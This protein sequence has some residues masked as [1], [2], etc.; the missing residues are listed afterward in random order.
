MALQG[1]SIQELQ[2]EVAAMNA[3]WQ[4]GETA[5]TEMSSDER[6]QYLGYVPGPDEPSLE[7][8]EQVAQAN[9]E[10]FYATAT[11]A[12]THP[13]SYDLRNVGGRN[14]I[15]AVKDQ[16]GC[17]SCVA[18]GV[19]A[20]AE[21]RFRRQRGNPKLAVDFSEA[22]LYFCN[23][24]RCTKAE[25]NY[26]WSSG[27][28][29]D[30]FRN[31][32]VVDE[33]CF[34]YKDSTQ[35]CKLCAGASSRLRKITGWKRITSTAEMKQWLSTKG[36]LVACYTVYDDFFAYRGGIYRHLRGEVAGGHCV[37]V[38]GY[39]D[40]ERYW[41]CK[42]SWGR[43]FG[44]ENP[45]D[46]GTPKEKGYFR[47]AY[48]QC[49]IDS[50]MDAVEMVAETGWE[51]NQRIIG[52]WTINEHRNAW[53]HVKDMGWR[54]ISPD[55]DPIFFIMLAQLIA[56][57]GGNRPVNFRQESSVIKQVTVL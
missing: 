27:P 42:N 21:G 11:D 56:A 36:P 15:T 17:G 22:H 55:N 4:A 24:R 34:P 25:G 9:L 47:I 49:G 57:K 50:S 26:G 8:R 19:A 14:Y 18:F 6:A 32:G 16:G 41:I 45:Y 20:S 31:N 43:S 44:E 23:G 46:T 7:E 30:Y 39:N 35:P 48:G 5:F 2:R 40:T 3:D 52:L 51:N 38:V 54:K 12:A 37:S 33:A 13:A 53:V 1:F 28:A 10:E 29:L